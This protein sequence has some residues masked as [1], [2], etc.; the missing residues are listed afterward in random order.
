MEK[1]LSFSLITIYTTRKPRD[2]DPSHYIHIDKIKFEELNNSSTFFYTISTS[3]G[4]FYGYVIPCN[5]KVVVSFIDHI[6]TSL[7]KSKL[8][9]MDYNVISFELVADCNVE[10]VIE[11]RGML[12][13]DVKAR[14]D[15]HCG[16]S[17]K[18]HRDSA[19]TYI[20]SE[21]IKYV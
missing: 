8:E 20:T 3:D 18:I 17:I 13:T 10:K 21:M 6:D 5:D 12:P 9:T 14:K 16:N 15:K 7:V 2:D 19:M 4:S 1:E 11:E